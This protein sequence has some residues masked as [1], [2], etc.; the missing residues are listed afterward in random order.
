[1]ENPLPMIRPSGCNP[2]RPLRR[3]ISFVAEHRWHC[4]WSTLPG[5]APC[6]RVHSHRCEPSAHRM[7]VILRHRLSAA[8]STDPTFVHRTGTPTPT[9]HR[10]CLVSRSP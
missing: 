8:L 1:M 7:G 9:P 2:Y 3:Q 10:T 5:P 4:P 6:S